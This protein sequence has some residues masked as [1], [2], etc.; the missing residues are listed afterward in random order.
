VFGLKRSYFFFFFAA[1]FAGFAFFLVAIFFYS[2]FPS[3]MEHCDITSSQ[4][5]LCIE[6]TK[7]IVKQKTRVRLSI[8]M[9]QP[10]RFSVLRVRP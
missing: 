8:S 9:T 4:F 5:V 1:F 2:P 10:E 3:V 7:K 6:S